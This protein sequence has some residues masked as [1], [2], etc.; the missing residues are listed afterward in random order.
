MMKKISA[1]VRSFSKNGVNMEL[2]THSVLALIA[3]AG[4][5]FAGFFMNI[6]VARYLGIDQAGYFFLAITVI[7]L[8][9]TFGRIGADNAVLRFVSVHSAK[10]EWEEVH[11]IIN[12]ILKWVWLI[13]GILTIVICLCSK[14]FAVYIFHK[15]EF[16]W[17]LFIASLSI[18]FIAVYT[19][20]GMALQGRK[21]PLLSV[22][23]IKIASPLFLIVLVIV[24]SATNSLQ[25]SIFFTISSILNVG[26][27]YYLWIKNT[28]FGI[29]K[30]EI[31]NLLSICL[32]LWIGSI[33]QQLILWGGQFVA[34]IYN[35]PAELAQLSVARNTSVLITF[36]LTAVNLVSAPRFASMYNQGKMEQLKKY[37]RNT[38]LLMT[39]VASPVLIFVLVFPSF[40]MSFFGKDYEGGISFLRVLAFGQYINVITGSVG[41]LL[42]MTGHEADMLRIRVIN[43]VGAIVLAFILNYLYGAIGS[44]IATSIAVAGSNLM[45]VSLVK[46][47]LGFNTMSTLGLGFFRK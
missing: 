7:T 9:A 47:R 34:G 19:I 24:F 6:V 18:P 41:Y 22:S 31:K 10:S 12:G 1:K 17:P 16:T 43:G 15:P 23:I 38:T 36:V 45:A 20:L 2:I 14:L 40:I 26:L 11:G 21:K 25:A 13:T 32:P 42:I 37:S 29:P 39:L 5:A 8:V 4:G 28:P 33:M 27:A 35:S 3:R 44:A 46:K 30:Y